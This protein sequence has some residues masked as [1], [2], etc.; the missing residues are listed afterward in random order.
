MVV[1]LGPG[2]DQTGERRRA[3]CNEPIRRRAD[4]LRIKPLTARKC[5]GLA[6]A[7]SGVG[8][9]RPEIRCSLR[10]RQTRRPY[11][12]PERTVII[13]RLA[14]ILLEAAGVPTREHDDER[15]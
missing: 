13:V 6:L 14:R 7:M 11:N 1:K 4:L 9:N 12:P 3:E 8:T 10:R 5:I 15:R 2:H